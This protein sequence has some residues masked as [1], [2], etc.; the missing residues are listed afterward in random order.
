MNTVRS[1][2]R[3]TTARGFKT[4]FSVRRV[5][6]LPYTALQQAERTAFTVHELYDGSVCTVF[7]VACTLYGAFTVHKV[8]ARP[9]ERHLPHTISTLDNAY[10]VY[11][12]RRST[13]DDVLGNCRARPP[14]LT[15]RTVFTVHK[16]HTLEGTYGV[17]CTQGLR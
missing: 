16:P 9:C 10:G 13:L 15:T 6:R 4:M 2:A 11:R 8:Y 7:T 3:A 14:C 17:C 5:R 12:T 1:H